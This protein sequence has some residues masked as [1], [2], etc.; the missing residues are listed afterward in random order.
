MRFA[1]LLPALVVMLLTQS[2]FA[3]KIADIAHL[4]GD[5]TNLLTGMGLV[6]GLKGT[7]DGGKFLPA[8]RPLAQLMKTFGQPPLN[9]SELEIANNVALVSVFAELPPGG[10][11]NGDKLDVKVA[12]IGAATS[13]KNG[14]LYMVTLNGPDGKPFKTVDNQGIANSK[15]FALANG[16]VDVDEINSPLKGNV[17]GGAVMEVDLPT[18]CVDNAGRFT[19]VVDRPAASWAMTGTIAKLINDTAQNGET[20]AVCGRCPQ[21]GGADSGSGPKSA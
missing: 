2:V 3:V 13:L 7:G 9:V 10:I 4:N 21:R 11:R 20:I 19:L 5:R 8:M 15:P 12:S 18:R 1:K 17:H 14:I 6:M 16:L